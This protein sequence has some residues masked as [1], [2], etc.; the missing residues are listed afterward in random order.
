MSIEDEDLHSRLVAARDK[1]LKA[2]MKEKSQ[3]CEDEKPGG[4]TPSQY[5]LPPGA[6][7]LQDLIE[8]R[9]MNF[10]QGNIFKAQYRRGTC[11]HSDALRDARKT[12]WF[13]QREVDR[14]ELE[15]E[16]RK[17][18]PGIDVETL[19]QG[20][21]GLKYETVAARSA[22]CGHAEQQ[23]HDRLSVS[24]PPDPSY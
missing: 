9:G 22:C 24:W 2:I 16:N 21:E 18:A 3:K 6:T 8:Y 15:E 11:S 7:D 12:L 14:L 23:E 19:D 17:K 10:A 5:G 13:A 4:S 20:F 1:R